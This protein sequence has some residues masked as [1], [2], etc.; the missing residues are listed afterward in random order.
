MNSGSIQSAGYAVL[1]SGLGKRRNRSA[2][3]VLTSIR[4]SADVTS[5]D[6]AHSWIAAQPGAVVAETL[7]LLLRRLIAH[8]H[9]RRDF[10]VA[11]GSKRLIDGHISWTAMVDVCKLSAVGAGTMLIP[12]LR[13]HGRGMLFTPRRLFRQSCLYLYAA[14]FAVE[15]DALAAATVIAHGAVVSVVHK[16]NIHIVVGTV[17][18]E[19]AAAPVAALV[20]K[21]DVTKAVIDAAIVA[22]VRAPAEALSITH[23]F[24][25]DADAQL[26]I[27]EAS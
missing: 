27:N 25:T 4:S 5:W 12:H 8:M 21:A 15:A 2:P 19:M 6:A 26:N 10:H 3:F 17:V 13:P 18:V 23:K 9:R 22:D 11:I 1:S 20:A 16:S 14:R 7:A 24:N